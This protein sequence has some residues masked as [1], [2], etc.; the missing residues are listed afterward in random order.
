MSRQNHKVNK[1]TEIPGMHLNIDAIRTTTNVPDCKT[2]KEL[3]EVISQHEHLQ[4]FK[5]H[6]IKG[7]SENKDQIPHDI[8]T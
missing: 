4:H 5:E 8:R 3:Q 6:N 1:N 2:L 7:L